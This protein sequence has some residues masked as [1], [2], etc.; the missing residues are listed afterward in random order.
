MP[1]PRILIIEDDADIRKLVQVGLTKK[2]FDT[3]T[4]SDGVEGLEA[5]RTHQPDLVVLDVTMPKLDGWGV[6]R[7][8]RSSGGFAFTPVVLLTA[9]GT[10]DHRL[11]GFRLG[12][13]DYIQK[14]FRMEEL[15][16]RVTRALRHRAQLIYF[17]KGLSRV[18]TQAAPGTTRGT[19][20]LFSVLTLLCMLNEQQRDGLLTLTNNAGGKVAR[21][22]LRGGMF[23]T[24]E[25]DGSPVD[26]TAG[27]SEIAAWREGAFE[28]VPETSEEPEAVNGDTFDLLAA[29][30]RSQPP[31]ENL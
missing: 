25:L 23:V 18:N 20:D 10:Q 21:V 28:F 30:R 31:G 9:L 17:A 8:L 19:L 6:L 26:H 3:L 1:N 22:R 4:A 13:D 27:L 14:P 15:E 5:A 24:V 11:D 29:A 7:E 16:L 2:G 12:A